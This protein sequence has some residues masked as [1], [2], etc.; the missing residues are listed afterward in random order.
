MMGMYD[1]LWVSCNLPG[2]DFKTAKD[3]DEIDREPRLFQTKSFKCTLTTFE[4]TEKRTLTYH[5]E[6]MDY[7]GDVNFYNFA[8]GEFDAS[9]IDGKMT[10][11]KK[12][13]N[14]W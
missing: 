7:T 3:D 8:C 4:L 10:S 14:L 9:F 5:G 2:T 6:P 12:R 1:E 13:N 11:I